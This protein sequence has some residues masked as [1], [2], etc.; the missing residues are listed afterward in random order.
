MSKETWNIVTS[1]IIEDVDIQL[2]LQCA[3]LIAGLKISNLLNIQKEQYRAVERILSGSNISWYVLLENGNTMVLLL[4]NTDSLVRYLNKTEVRQML[5]DEGYENTLT[6]NVLKEF[7]GRYQD[8]MKNR[9]VFPHEMGLLLGYPVEDVR[10]FIECRG[11]QPLYTGYWKVYKD[12]DKKIR[13]FERF[14]S[15]KESMIQLLGRGICMVDIIDIYSTC[16]DA[17]KKVS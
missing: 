16:R 6:T 3:P 11:L 14:E 1:K 9:N 15:A 10:G 8:Y 17:L 7:S 12:K 4:Y 13:L 2:A 5:L